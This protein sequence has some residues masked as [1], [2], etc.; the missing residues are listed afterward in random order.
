MSSEDFPVQDPLADS[1]STEAQER[2]LS[3]AEENMT[4]KGAHLP[5]AKHELS[6]SK[7]DT[8]VSAHRHLGES[9][10]REVTHKYEPAEEPKEQETPT[11][12]P[13][14]RISDYRRHDQG[15][16]PT[17]QRRGKP[18]LEPRSSI[19]IAIRKHSAEHPASHPSTTSER[20]SGGIRVVEK[21]RDAH[22]HLQL[23][24]EDTSASEVVTEATIEAEGA[25][26][27]SS[28]SSSSIGDWDF[29]EGLSR[30]KD[31][32]TGEYRT[33][34]ILKIASSAERIIMG[35]DS[36]GSDYAVTQ[37]SNPALVVYPDT[38]RRSSKRALA[39]TG[40]PGFSGEG[41]HTAETTPA[42]QTLNRPMISLE[43]FP[44]RD[45]SGREWA[46]QRKPVNS[47]SL[48]AL[49]TPSPESQVVPMVPKLPKPYEELMSE[50]TSSEPMTPTKAVSHQYETSSHHETSESDTTIKSHPRRTVSTQAVSDFPLYDDA[51]TNPVSSTTVDSINLS[52]STEEVN[53]EAGLQQGHN[54]EQTPSKARLPEP[55]SSRMLDGFRNIFKH[56]STLDNL[57][58]KGESSQPSSLASKDQASSGTQ[59]LRTPENNKLS[60]GKPGIKGK[61]KYTRLSDG[62]S[63]NI[64]IAR[65]LTG[66]P[67][68]ARPTISSP[69]PAPPGHPLKDS[70]SSFARPTKAT[71]TRAIAN[72]RI[73][74]A[75]AAH[76]LA[77]R[78]HT[79]TSSTGCPQL[80]SHPTK[81]SQGTMP[82]GIKKANLPCSARSNELNTMSSPRQD[83]EKESNAPVSVIEMLNEIHLCIETLCNNARDEET[84]AERE[85][86]LRMALVLQQQVSDYNGVKKE[87]KEAENLLTK[88]CGDQCVAENVLFESYAQIR[89]Q[90]DEA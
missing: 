31:V 86:Y 53:L 74:T 17:S 57:H 34:P 26:S 51:T 15:L 11:P 81:G 70:G 33:R 19:P 5:A 24:Q 87:V 1:L 54:D 65:R 82:S 42:A 55:K 69:M 20:S 71:R 67:T 58:D 85:K 6:S 60:P 8:L 78:S 48:T 77:R 7:G 10:E 75:T 21:P 32:Y 4:T 28:S 59:I 22:S 62:W 52:R 14:T 29:G 68:K 43:T 9:H 35:P 64:R 41:S 90:M 16:A 3:S 84:P 79:V 37:R 45:I 38:P 36:P 66:T 40:A 63:K 23:D 49:F 73:Q 47:P 39:N 25:D 2:T 44:K 13:S 56:R 30:P 18:T 72:P 50:A 83:P 88:K 89:T 27:S 61:G 12:Q 80:A 76:S 46:I